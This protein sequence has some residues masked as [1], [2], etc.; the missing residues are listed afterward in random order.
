MEQIIN[1]IYYHCYCINDFYSRFLKTYLKIEKSNLI[2]IINN[3]NIIC[4]GDSRGIFNDFNKVNV[5]HYTGSALSEAVT[6]NYLK[7]TIEANNVLYLHSKGVTRNKNKNV[8]DWIDYME[9]F[10]IEDYK[11]RI[12][13][14]QA[15]DVTG[16]N[17]QQFK[18]Q[19][20]Y[21]GN[22]WWATGKHI[23]TLNYCNEIDRHKAEMWV[24]SNPTG[25][26]NCVYRSEIDHYQN[27]YVRENYTKQLPIV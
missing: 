18:N 13:E 7:L 19:N 21:S 6:L 16:V 23:K 12:A 15:N 25:R 8:E 4:I 14:L 3:I 17:L 20:H 5:I 10:C 2:S 22:F 9:Y 27:Q 1:S 11:N 26:Y 24:C